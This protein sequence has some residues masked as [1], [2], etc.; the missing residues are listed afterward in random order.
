MTC[1]GRNRTRAS[2]VGS[3]HSRKEPFEHLVNGYSEH[4][5]VNAATGDL[6]RK[7]FEKKA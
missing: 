3:K 5:P 1:P 7:C 4:K 6:F 2:R